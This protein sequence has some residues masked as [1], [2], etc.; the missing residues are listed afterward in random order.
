MKFGSV[1]SVCT[2]LRN[3]GART[4]LR[5]IAKN[6][7]QDRG[8]DPEEADGQ[9]VHQHL[10]DLGHLR[11]RA[12][13][14]L[15]PLQSDELAALEAERRLV[16]VQRV[17]PA[18]QRQVREQEREDQEA[19]GCTGTAV[20]DLRLPAGSAAAGRA[21]STRSSRGCGSPLPGRRPAPAPASSSRAR[22]GCGIRDGCRRVG[23]TPL[24]VTPSCTWLP[25][26]RGADPSHRRSASISNRFDRKSRREHADYVKCPRRN[27]EVT[28][29]SRPP[30]R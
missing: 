17:D 26:R 19:G 30:G 15:E 14:H 27:A 7:R 21:A 23:R 10:P 13:Q 8:R 29:A 1:V 22:P 9:G 2:E 20:N 12:D 28:I 25:L 11:R 3:Q 16:V 4:S 5:K 6:E 18:V 24:H